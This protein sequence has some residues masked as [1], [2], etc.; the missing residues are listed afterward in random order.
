VA[1]R[2]PDNDKQDLPGCQT[3]EGTVSRS[4]LCPA[5]SLALQLGILS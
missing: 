5:P 2:L 1:V 3:T 4:E